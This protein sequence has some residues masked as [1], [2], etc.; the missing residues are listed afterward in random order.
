MHHLLQEADDPHLQ[1][2][3]QLKVLRT[4]RVI[5]GGRGPEKQRGEE[6]MTERRVPAGV[7]TPNDA[8]HLRLCWWQLF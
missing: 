1:L 2:R 7:W 3:V 6:E 8:A 5:T 4:D